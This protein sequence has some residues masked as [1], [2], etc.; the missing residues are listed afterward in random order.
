VTVILVLAVRVDPVVVMTTRVDVGDTV[1]PEPP[2]MTTLGI[3]SAEI[4]FVG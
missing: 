4:K 2:L 3:A 1:V